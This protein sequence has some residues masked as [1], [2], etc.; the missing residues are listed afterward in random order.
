MQPA[1]LSRADAMTEARDALLRHREFVGYALRELRGEDMSAVRLRTAR[2]D[3][4]AVI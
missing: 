1:A 2:K 3:L 4:T